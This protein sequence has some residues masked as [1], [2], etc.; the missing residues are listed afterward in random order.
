MDV[1]SELL[2][3]R[4]LDDGSRL[5]R[6]QNTAIA[7]RRTDVKRTSSARS[8]AGFCTL[9]LSRGSLNPMSCRIY[10]LRTSAVAMGENVSGFNEDE[11]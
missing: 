8:I 9:L 1:D 6:L 10:P 5:S 11:H 7:L 4:E 3:E 2:T